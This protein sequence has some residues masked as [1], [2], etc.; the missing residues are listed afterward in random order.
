MYVVKVFLTHKN[1]TNHE[2]LHNA[3]IASWG[4]L[5]R[6]DVLKY[7]TEQGRLHQQIGE[8]FGGNRFV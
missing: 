1:P 8:H 6:R 3:V 2:D 4:N 5:H 7:I